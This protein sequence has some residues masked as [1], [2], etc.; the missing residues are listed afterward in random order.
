VHIRLDQETLRPTPWEAPG[1]AVLES[2][3]AE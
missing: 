3:R 2:L 1:R